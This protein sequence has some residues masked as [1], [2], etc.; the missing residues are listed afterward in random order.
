[1]KILI[2]PDSFKE[3]LGA[4]EFCQVASQAIKSISP[5][6]E[7]TQMP[8]S[9]GGEGMV[10]SL[11]ILPNSKKIN[12]SSTNPIG[13]PINCYYN[14]IE[15]TKTAIIEM[16][17]ASGLMLL[18]DFEKNALQTSTIGTGKIIQHALN[19]GAKKL[20]I[21][22][23]GSATTDAG[24]G[25]LAK[26]GFKFLN[27]QGKSVSLDGAGLKSIHKIIMPETDYSEFDIQVASDV[28]NLLYG[29]QGSAYI[30][31]PQKGA[32]GAEVRQLDDGLKNFATV[33][34]RDLGIDLAEVVGAGAGGGMGA[35]LLLMGAK[36]KS[37]FKIIS[38]LIGFEK[39]FKKYQFDLVITG[40]GKLD[41]QSLNG[42]VPIEVAK[43]AKR[44][45]VATL[46]VFG[47]IDM[48][49]KLAYEHGFDAIFSI[50]NQPITLKQSQKQA[51]EL[52]YKQVQ[53]LI[54]FKYHS[55]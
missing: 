10:D 40:E 50:T 43:I 1:M 55:I 38:D 47:M 28:N 41:Q 12:L 11:L 22:L 3:S 7:I 9:D 19:K 4:E 39:L 13:K 25:C 18:N 49:N 32:S 29:R 30:F 46:G 33:V 26:L 44:H 6:I 20:I 45:K 51:K 21:G 36:S 42:K 37:G 23:G 24:I 2:S 34:K 15:T 16:A 54:R 53:N 14:Y 52:L 35:G 27:A 5:E 48:E 31:A 8:M 17:S